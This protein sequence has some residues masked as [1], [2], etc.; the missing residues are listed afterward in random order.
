M[1]TV[2]LVHLIMSAA[3]YILFPSASCNNSGVLHVL[4]VFALQVGQG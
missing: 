4:C 3:D 1:D 2:S